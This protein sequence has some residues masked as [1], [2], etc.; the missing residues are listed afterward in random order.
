MPF[1]IS[2]KVAHWLKAL[3]ATAISGAANSGA[4]IIVDPNDFNLGAGLKK[5]V[6]VAIILAIKDVFL[7]IRKRPLPD[8]E[9]DGDQVKDV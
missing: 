7:F 1:S 4:L 9:V 6:L 5:L 3:A 8:V 2:P